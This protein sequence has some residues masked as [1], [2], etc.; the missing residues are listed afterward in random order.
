MLLQGV[1]ETARWTLEKSKAIRTLLEE[2]TERLRRDTA[3]IYSRELAG[4]VFEP[5]YRRIAHVVEA[6]LAKRQLGASP[7][8]R[9]K[10]L[11]E[12]GVLRF[13]PSLWHVAIG[14]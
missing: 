7:R 2:P 6:G 13:M 10:D 1:T 12:N 4:L 3:Q 8:P 14:L 11:Q 9:S 5:P